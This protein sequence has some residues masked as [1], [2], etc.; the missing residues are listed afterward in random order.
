MNAYRFFRQEMKHEI[1]L[2]SQEALRTHVMEWS[3]KTTENGF[4]TL[5][6][7]V[8]IVHSIFYICILNALLPSFILSYAKTNSTYY[9]LYV[10]EK[11]S[12]SSINGPKKSLWSEPV[13]IS[14]LPTK[15]NT[16]HKSLKQEPFVLNFIQI[17]YI[18]TSHLCSH[19]NMPLSFPNVEPSVFWSTEMSANPNQHWGGKNYTSVSRFVTRIAVLWM[20]WM[21]KKRAL[22]PGTVENSPADDLFAGHCPAVFVRSL[23]SFFIVRCGWFLTFFL[24]P[25]FTML[26]TPCHSTHLAGVQVLN[27]PTKSR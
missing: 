11:K 22:L 8:R 24:I 7:T 26:Q 17:S 18:H 1:R 4:K 27:N 5:L 21:N 19:S 15:Y 23:L 20:Q 10:H 13:I 9:L 3:A 6:Q 12:I 16:R 14:S 2:A 25:N